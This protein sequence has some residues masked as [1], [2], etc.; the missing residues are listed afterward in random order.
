MIKELETLNYV[1]IENISDYNPVFK[2]IQRPYY[3]HNASIK[4]FDK[5]VT[6]TG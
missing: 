6:L 4:P 2:S 1:E 3:V 5:T